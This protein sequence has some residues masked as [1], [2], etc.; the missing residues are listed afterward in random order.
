MPGATDTNFFHRA[1]MDNTRVGQ[2]K[3][4]DPAEVAR[5]G[6]E[7]MMAGKDH[8][9]AGSFMNM[10]TVQATMAHVLPDTMTADLHRKQA[11]HQKP[12]TFTCASFMPVL[13]R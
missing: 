9:I 10:N 11:G 13:C 3:K 2:G 4:D 8:V 7:A 6:F 12:Q 1:D 5:E